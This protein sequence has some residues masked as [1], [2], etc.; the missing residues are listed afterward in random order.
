MAQFEAWENEYLRPQLLTGRDAPQNDVLRFLK[1]VKK[2]GGKKI[3]NL[4]I[5][6]LGSGT[7]RNAN[8]LAEL[9]ANVIGMEISPTAIKIAQTRAREM[10]IDVKYLNH[11]I[12]TVYPFKD[13]YFDLILDVTSSNSLNEKEREIY[14]AETRR[15]LKPDGYIFV[16][17]LSK[18]GDKNAKNLIKISPG[19]EPDTYFMKELGLIERVFSEEDFRKLYG[20][21]FTIDELMKKKGYARLQ[22][23]PYKRI[24]FLAYLTSLGE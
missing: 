8:Y 2:T 20:Q 16:R 15:V 23:K 1:F 7:G 17:A 13:N 19:Q 14:L 5:L 6:D 11:N 3:E 21:Y 12:G 4:N 22:G 9:G 10:L 24:Y 18:D